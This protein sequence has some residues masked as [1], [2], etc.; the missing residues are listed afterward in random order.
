MEV[1]E[2]RRLR[3][4]RYH[5]R[6]TH[7]TLLN[8][9]LSVWHHLFFFSFNLLVVVMETTLKKIEHFCGHAGVFQKLAMFPP[10]GERKKVSLRQ[11]YSKFC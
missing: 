5:Q 11:M 1:S 8:Q 9:I 4:P 3:L 7:G 6:W 10:S 2:K